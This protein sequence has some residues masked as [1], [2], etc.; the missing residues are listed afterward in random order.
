MSAILFVPEVS[1]VNIWKRRQEYN[2]LNVPLQRIS[3]KT[4]GVYQFIT[5]YI[6]EIECNV[7]VHISTFHVY[8]MSK[9]YNLHSIL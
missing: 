4:Q 2:Q 1:Y 3:I 9:I 6:N 7:I 5:C 8:N